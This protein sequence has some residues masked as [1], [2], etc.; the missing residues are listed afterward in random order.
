MLYQK[1]YNEQNYVFSKLMKV[2][3]TPSA[4]R[5]VAYT[6]PTLGV[7]KRRFGSVAGSL[8]AKYEFYFKK[9]WTL[10]ALQ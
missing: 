10:R 9:K 7:A 1:T 3:V 8:I 5:E 2:G 6:F 4:K